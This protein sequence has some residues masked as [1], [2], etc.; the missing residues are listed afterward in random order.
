MVELKSSRHPSAVGWGEVED[1]GRC[2]TATWKDNYRAIIA[3]SRHLE[4]SKKC[5]LLSSN[6]GKLSAPVSKSN[7]QTSGMAILGTPYFSEYWNQRGEPQ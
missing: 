3:L 2:M 5:L 7:A 4:A 6:M 1:T